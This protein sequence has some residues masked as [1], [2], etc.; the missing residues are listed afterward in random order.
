MQFFISKAKQIT[1]LSIFK[2]KFYRGIF[3]FFLL[4]TLLYLPF[5]DSLCRRMLGSTLASA[6]R[7]SNHSD[8][9]H[10]HSARSHPHSDRFHLHSTRSHPH[11]PRSHPHSPRSHPHY[12][13][14]Y[15]YTFLKFLILNIFQ[16]FG[17]P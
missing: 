10:L 2:Q 15:P 8:R 6:D 9:S 11:S 12:S 1:V 4:S 16:L 17:Y 5:L 14:M 7:C 13:V 3:Q